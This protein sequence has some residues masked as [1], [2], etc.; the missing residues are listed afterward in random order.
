[1][2]SLIGALF[3][4][5]CMTPPPFF[6]RIEVNLI[7][8]VFYLV[9]LGYCAGLVIHRFVTQH[10]GRIESVGSIPLRGLFVIFIS[11]RSFY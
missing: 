11:C 10:P 4:G 6:A 3:S 2:L 5:G 7:D 8:V 9:W 1:M